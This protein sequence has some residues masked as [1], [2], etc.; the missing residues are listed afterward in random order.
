MRIFS[1]AHHMNIQLRNLLGNSCK[2]SVF[3]MMHEIWKIGNH[4]SLLSI[5]N[6]HFQCL[7]KQIVLLE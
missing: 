3:Y 1:D 4:T 5:E 7:V 6:L 2:S